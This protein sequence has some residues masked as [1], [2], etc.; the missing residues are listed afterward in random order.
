MRKFLTKG[1][2]DMF[3]DC[4]HVSVKKTRYLMAVKP[5]GVMLKSHFKRKHLIRLIQDNLRI[6]SHWLHVVRVVNHSFVFILTQR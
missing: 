5:N 6:V 3:T 1:I 4:L 2:I